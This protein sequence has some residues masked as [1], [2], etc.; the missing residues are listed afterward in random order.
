MTDR[1]A[2]CGRQQVCVALFGRYTDHDQHC[3]Q[4]KVPQA[5]IRTRSPGSAP[6][7][8]CLLIALA[9]R[10]CQSTRTIT[11]IASLMEFPPRII[12]FSVH[13]NSQVRVTVP[14]LQTFLLL[15]ASTP[16]WSAS[17]KAT[18][19]RPFPFSNKIHGSL[20]AN[21]YNYR[22]AIFQ[23]GFCVPGYI[24]VPRLCCNLVRKYQ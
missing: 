6:R 14:L 1:L 9:P 4:Y 8:G 20:E 18:N 12:L 21:T 7:R 11:R 2:E 10:I 16:L 3:S 13:I 23:V 22:I 17:V 15:T 5:I 24:L 19:Q